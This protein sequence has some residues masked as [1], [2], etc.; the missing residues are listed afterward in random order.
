MEGG[1]SS[2]RWIGGDGFDLAV[3]DS[4]LFLKGD[5]FDFA[6]GDSRLVLGLGMLLNM[7]AG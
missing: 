6:V 1:R 2:T 7:R 5:V 4:R 3:G